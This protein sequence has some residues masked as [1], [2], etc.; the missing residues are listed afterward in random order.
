MSDI[1]DVSLSFCCQKDWN[2]FTTVDERTRFC[3]SCKLNVIDFTRS[4][5]A[6]LRTASKN[7]SVCGRFKLSQM[8]ET[9]LKSAAATLIIA[10]AAT[11]MQCSEEPIKAEPPVTPLVQDQEFE[12]MGDVAFTGLMTESEDST[13]IAIDAIQAK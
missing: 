13:I 4:T 3:S 8:S 12:L 11:A 2:K 6:D 1:K 5:Q 7:G 9:F 10:S